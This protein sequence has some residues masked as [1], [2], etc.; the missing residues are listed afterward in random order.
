MH[1]TIYFLALFFLPTFAHPFIPQPGTFINVRGQ[2]GKT[3]IAVILGF[4]G[5]DII[6]AYVTN[7]PGHGKL[8][9]QEKDMEEFQ[10]PVALKGW[11]VQICGTVMDMNTA[12]E[13]TMTPLSPLSLRLLR[14]RVNRE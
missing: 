1:F 5:V 8:N 14:E 10:T 11:V 12:T 2:G 6:G 9:P 7:R 4:Q 13:N 3:S